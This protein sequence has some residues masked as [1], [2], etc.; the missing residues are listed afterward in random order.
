[1]G[2]TS[3]KT[4][5]RADGGRQSPQLPLLCDRVGGFCV[6]CGRKTHRLHDHGSDVVL[7][8]SGAAALRLSSGKVALVDRED[9]GRVIAA[10]PWAAVWNGKLWYA[11]NNSAGYLHRFILGVSDAALVDHKNLNTLDCRRE[12]LRRATHSQNVCNRAKKRYAA[13]VSSRYKGVDLHCG[14]WR[15]QIAKH[16]VRLHLG[17]FDS[18]ED[19]ALAYDTAARKLHG[20]FARLNF[21]EAGESTAIPVIDAGELASRKGFPEPRPPA[22]NPRVRTAVMAAT[23][24]RRRP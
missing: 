16:G 15:A 9:V 1:M 21:P 20:E 18:E 4:I 11:V 24:W 22:V 6:A 10:G 8:P 14:R 13:G 23:A 17:V 3:T 19:A 7:L 5:T 2:S 12:N